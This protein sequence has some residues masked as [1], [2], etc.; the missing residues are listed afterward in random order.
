MK[1]EIAKIWVEALRSGKYEQTRG[2]LKMDESY[3]CLG[4]L[5]EIS[6]LGRFSNNER[7]LIQ[8]RSAQE[9]KNDVLPVSVMKWAGIKDSS[10]LLNMYES[11]AEYNDSGKT[12]L[13]I[14]DIIELNVE[15]L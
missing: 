5:C 12:F 4:V 2:Q 10:G 6:K 15:N 9:I 11:L 1:K 3:C 8:S 13:E 14:A 7:Y